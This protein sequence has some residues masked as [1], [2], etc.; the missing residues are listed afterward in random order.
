MLT[1]LFFL[2]KTFDFLLHP[3]TPALV[4][5]LC[6][7]GLLPVWTTTVSFSRAPYHP[8][9]VHSP[10]C[11]SVIFLKLISVCDYSLLARSD[12]NS[13]ICPSITLPFQ[14]FLP[15]YTLPADI[16]RWTNYTGPLDLGAC[17]RN[18]LLFGK[19]KVPSNDW[20]SHSLLWNLPWLIQAASISCF[21]VL[22]LYG[23]SY[24]CWYNSSLNLPLIL[25]WDFED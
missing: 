18:A 5:T 13:D 7:P 17:C 19:Y 12:I 6:L 3:A 14:T 15:I 8:S 25:G 16:T 4:P 2:Q 9:A 23:F 22:S 10:R 20:L 1:S 21:F 11:S 24:L